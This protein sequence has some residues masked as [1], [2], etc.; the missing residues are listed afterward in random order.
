MLFPPLLDCIPSHALLLRPLLSRTLC[1]SG[2][3]AQSRTE[4]I[5]APG[6]P[7]QESRSRHKQRARGRGEAGGGRGRPVTRPRLLGRCPPVRRGGGEEGRRGRRASDRDGRLR[8][9]RLPWEE[10]RDQRARGGQRV[11]EKPPPLPQFSPAP[12]PWLRRAPFSGSGGADGGGGRA[13]GMVLC[14]PTTNVIQ[15]VCNERCSDFSVRPITS[16]L[17]CDMHR[18]NF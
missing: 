16:S 10:E 14:V 2:C 18:S 4:S 12:T 7:A 11:G 5:G 17:A 3:A 13:D 6:R 15:R 9:S 1:L 8:H